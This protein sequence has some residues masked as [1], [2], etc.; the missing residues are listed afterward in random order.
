MTYLETF[1][2]AFAEQFGKNASY[3]VAITLPLC[4]AVLVGRSV[5]AWYRLRHI[6]GPW[7]AAWSDLWLINSII[8]GRMHWKYADACEKYGMLVTGG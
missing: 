7:L 3:Y 5:Y 8:S 2:S 4:V 6:K 1:S